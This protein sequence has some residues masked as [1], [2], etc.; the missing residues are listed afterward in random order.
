M[1]GAEALILDLIKTRTGRVVVG[2]AMIAAGMFFWLLSY[3]Q[4]RDV[5]ALCSQ[6][7]R[8]SAEVYE[9]RISHDV[10]GIK[11][12][13]DI[14]YRFRLD[15]AGPW[16]TQSEKGLLARH[17][18]W[19]SL[20]KEAWEEAKSSSQVQVDYLPSDPSVNCVAG[21]AAKERTGVYGLMGFAALMAVPGALMAANGIYRL[22]FPRSSPQ[23]VPL[24][25][26]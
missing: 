24:T 12:H 11:K 9:T 3:P 21:A 13:Y 14:R 5:R 23:L 22:M 6:A 16:Y 2:F 4:L 10:H 25:R 17:E 15:P 26:Q 7:R 19:T 8:V 18:L 1:I 20:P